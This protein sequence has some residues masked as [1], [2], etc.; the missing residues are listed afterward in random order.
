ME[1]DP[2]YLL[3]GNIRVAKP[4]TQEVMAVGFRTKF[5]FCLLV[6]PLKKFN[7]HAQWQHIR[8]SVAIITSGLGLPT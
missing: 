7:L 1:K 2:I 5:R 3:Y 6:Q 4:R 8:S